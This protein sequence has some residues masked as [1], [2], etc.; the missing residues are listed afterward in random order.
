MWACMRLEDEH[1]SEWRDG[2]TGAESR[3]NGRRPNQIIAM[4]VGTGAAGVNRLKIIDV[5]VS[6]N[7][8]S[9]HR[10][11]NGEEANEEPPV[12]GYFEDAVY[13]EEVTIVHGFM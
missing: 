7:R 6:S 12:W 8:M 10:A 4:N 13:C 9:N 3:G 11:R 1:E 5:Y 2:V